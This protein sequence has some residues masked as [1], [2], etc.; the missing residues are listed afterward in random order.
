MKNIGGAMLTGSIMAGTGFSLNARAAAAASP[1]TDTTASS[2]VEVDRIAADP[3][4]IPGPIRRN[5]PKTHEIEL[6]SREVISEIEDGVQF[7]Y[8]TFGGQVPGPFIRVRQGDTVIL[9][10]KSAPENVLLHNVDFHSVYGTGGG[11]EATFVTP[12]QSQT[13]KF[14][15]MYPGAYIYHCAVP[16]MDYH[17]SSGMYGMMLVE[18]EEGLPEV[19]HEFYFGQNEIYSQQLAGEKGMHEFN[20]EDMRK[21]TPQYVLLNGE[22]QAITAN[23]RGALKVKKGEKARIFFVNG[24]PNLSSSFHPIG[25]VWTKTWREGAIASNPERFVQTALVPPGSCGI[26]EMDFPVA[27]TVHLVDHALSRVANKGMMGDIIV[28]GPEDPEIFDPNYSA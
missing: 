8:L 1:K 14:K 20:F 11:A 5:T 26:F 27:S 23:R 2:A 6:V 15:A 4:A 22:K 10:H 9:T 19:D 3:T 21:E 16:R 13:I 17:I 18:P 24:G 28:E 7:H 12:G 25:N